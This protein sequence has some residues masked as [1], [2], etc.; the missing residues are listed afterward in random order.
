MG[1]GS[2]KKG[3]KK[4]K[5]AVAKLEKQRQEELQVHMEN[6]FFFFFFPLKFFSPSIE[7]CF[8][9]CGRVRGSAIAQKGRKGSEKGAEKE[10]Q[11]HD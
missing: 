2:F 1:F 6:T 10:E 11:S 8:G 9:F 5:K 4:L 3:T 7:H